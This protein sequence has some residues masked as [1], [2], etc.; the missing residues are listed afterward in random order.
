M[1]I[2]FIF[3]ILETEVSQKRL[4]ESSLTEIATIIRSLMSE[5]GLFSWK[6]VV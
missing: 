5:G 6:D 4:V 2:L 1:A 3:F